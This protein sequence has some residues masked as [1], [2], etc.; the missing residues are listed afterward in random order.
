MTDQSLSTEA[1]LLDLVRHQ[2]QENL[3]LEYKRSEALGKSSKQRDEIAKDVSALANSAGGTLIY[4]VQE[5][6][7]M[8]IGLDRGV[9]PTDIS[10]EWL[11]Q[12][13]TSLVKPRI[14]GLRIVGVEL[15]TIAPGRMAFVVT[16]PQSF[17][18]PHMAGNRYYKRHGTTVLAMEDYEVRDVMRRQDAPLLT[19]HA[20][21]FAA[22]GQAAGYPDLTAVTIDPAI[23]NTG[24][25]PAEHAIIE[26]FIDARLALVDHTDWRRQPGTVR[27]QVGGV[28]VDAWRLS[29]NWSVPGKLPIWSGLVFGVADQPIRFAISTAEEEYVLAWRVS[30]PHM[31]QQVGSYVLSR[32]SDQMTLVQAAADVVLP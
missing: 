26:F 16:V 2:V 20:Q 7:P 29:F 4:G 11:E 23:E 5:D 15:S 19:L 32:R 9:D 6:G 30:A 10:R 22:G 12:V 8:P 3:E 13:I 24:R 27:I 18:A 21:G 14:D 17:R 1:N 25:T 31:S 28:N